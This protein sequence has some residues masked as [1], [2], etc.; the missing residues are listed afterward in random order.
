MRDGPRG[1]SKKPHYLRGITNKLVLQ[2]VRG[3]PF[4]VFVSPCSDPEL[5]APIDAKKILELENHHVSWLHV[6]SYVF[7]FNLAH[8]VI[9]VPASF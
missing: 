2:A 1:T 6:Y 7:A 4:W 5:E 8:C 3:S 9:I